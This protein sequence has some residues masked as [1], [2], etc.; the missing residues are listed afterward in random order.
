MILNGWPSQKESLP[1]ELYH[2]FNI[3][4]ELAAQD[5]VIF[6]GPKPIIPTSL[7]AKI[8]KK[9]PQIPYRY[10]RMPEKGTRSCVLAQ[11]EQRTGR[12]YLKV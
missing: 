11:H 8:K 12:F 9:A 2:Y 6:K 3:R 5:G 7:R 1:T 10:S 4:D